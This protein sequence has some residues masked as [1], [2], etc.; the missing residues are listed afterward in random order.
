MLRTILLSSLAL[1]GVGFAL[2]MSQ[3]TNATVPIAKPA[4][5]PAASPFARTIAGAGIVEARG[6]NISIGTPVAGI[7]TDI[8]VKIGAPLEI[9]TPLFQ[10]DNRNLTA[11]LITKKAAASTAAQRVDRLLKMPRAEE[12]APARARVDAANA[13]LA[14]V[15]FQLQIAETAN[16]K[17]PGSMAVEE[18]TR[19]KHA[20]QSAEARAAEARSELQLI[21]AGAWA[22]DIEVARAE[23]ASAQ[24]EM[25][26]TEIELDRLLVKSPIRGEVFKVNIR[27]GEYAGAT[28]GG[29]LVIGD[30][31]KM[32]VRVDIDESDIWRFQVDS[33]AVAMV[34]G[35]T[36]FQ[37]SLAFDRREPLVIPKRSL[38]GESNERVDTR[39]LQVIYSFDRGAIPV[40]VGE[41]V[42][43]FI[44]ITNATANEGRP[45]SAP[46]PSNSVR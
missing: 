38:T 14:D 7:V 35:N 31:S 12:V 23:L 26:A 32:N 33:P 4:A 15:Q 20:V 42:D 46:S 1:A 43:V 39:V 27:K 36:H 29:L 22:P 6:E 45:A 25:K 11:Q 8:F 9:G 24:A 44:D 37:A 34:R 13:T 21:E 19:R 16:A 18:W 10:I 41:Q 40:H 2:F 30:L 3:R 5:S 28:G 17:L